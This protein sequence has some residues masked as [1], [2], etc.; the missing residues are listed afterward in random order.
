MIRWIDSL[1]IKLGY[2]K[3]VQFD[4]VN[5]ELESTNRR[6]GRYIEYA[7]SV[8][9][10]AGS[11]PNWKAQQEFRQIIHECALGK[12]AQSPVPLDDYLGK[13]VDETTRLLAND[14]ALHSASNASTY[15]DESFLAHARGKAPTRIN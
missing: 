12:C 11:Y 9:L 2:V 3:K 1:I 15:F 14:H 8:Y 7:R 4:S 13:V 10:Y 5:Q 6:L